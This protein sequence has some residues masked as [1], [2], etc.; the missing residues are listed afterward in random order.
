L[1]D[2]V[3]DGRITIKINLKLISC[4]R[5]RWINLVSRKGQLAGSFEHGNEPL[6]NIN[7][8]ETEFFNQDCFIKVY[9]YVIS[10]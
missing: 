9:E 8:G 2:L 10:T 1:E 7:L 4:K 3:I 5:V 6:F